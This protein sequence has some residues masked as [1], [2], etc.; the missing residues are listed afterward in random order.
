M[1]LQATNSSLSC[2]TCRSYLNLTALK[3][4]ASRGCAKISSFSSVSACSSS[5]SSYS[6]AAD[7]SFELVSSRE[8]DVFRSAFGV[9]DQRL[10]DLS[11]A[12]L[13]ARFGE[14]CKQDEERFKASKRDLV[15]GLALV[16]RRWTVSCL[17]ETYGD[18]IDLP[19][20]VE[21]EAACRP[22]GEK[23]HRVASDSPKVLRDAKGCERLGNC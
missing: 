17:I 13:L 19:V 2:S 6:K 11:L 3:V 10:S 9:T 12:L 18:K 1:C 7:V 23:S 16:R 22:E 8:L 5:S 4:S 20:E 21:G 14:D 15:L